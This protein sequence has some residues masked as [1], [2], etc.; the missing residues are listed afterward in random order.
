MVKRLL[1]VDDE[2]EICDF[3]KSFFEDRQYLVETAHSGVQAFGES[4]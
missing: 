3:L 4:S 1:V 2:V